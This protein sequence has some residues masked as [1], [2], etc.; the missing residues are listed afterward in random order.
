M[1]RRRPVL[2][3]TLGVVTGVLAGSIALT[4]FGI[5]SFIEGLASLVIVWLSAAPASPRIGPRDGRRNLSRSSSSFLFPSS[6]T[7]R[8]AN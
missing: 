1:S 3:Q 4:A 2:R 7:K 6:V 8:S 5:Q